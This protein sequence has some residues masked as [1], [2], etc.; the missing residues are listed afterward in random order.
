MTTS[1]L[2]PPSQARRSKRTRRR[3]QDK[4]SISARL[5]LD[6]HEVRGDVGI[7]SEDLFTDLFPHLRDVLSREDGSEDIHHIAIAPWE[8]NPSPTETAWTVVPVLKSSA[9]KPSTVQFSPSSLS[10]QN[11]ATILQQVAPS[12]LSS[13]SRSGIE[14]QILD[15]V[16][17]SLDTVFVSLESELTKR[18]EQGEG[19]FFRD[20]PNH[21]KGKGLVAPETPEGR[22]IASL[23]V[24]LGSLKVLH[25][26][27]LF[28]LPLP[29]HPV[30]HVPPNPGKIMLCE[31]VS[32]GILSEN[33]KIVLMRGRVH[34]KRSHAAPTIP[35]NRGLNGVPEDDEDDTANDQFYSAA[36]DRYKTDAATTEIDSVT[37]TEES[38][39]SGVDHDD[40][41][42]DDSM[43][44]MISLQAPTLPTTASGVSTMQPGTPM[45][46]GRGRKTNGIATPA[47]VFSNFTATTARPDRPRGRLFKAQGLVRPIPVDLLHP[48]PASE[49]DDEARI[50]VD[51]SSLSKIGCF[52]GDWVRVEAAEEPPAN[53]FGAFGLGSFTSLEPTESNWRPVRVY[54]LPEAYSQRPVTRI[55]SAKHGERR[56]SFFESQL[57]KPTSPAAY[58]SPILL[59]NLDSPSYLRL[60]P[61]KRGSYQGKGTLPKFTS[62]SRPPYARDITIQHVRSPVTAE[63]VYQ[64]AVLG[65]LKRYFA[66]KIR[67]VRTGDLLAVPIDTQLG[68]ALQ[69]QPSASNGSEVD[70]VMTLTKNGP[71][72]FDEVA[73]FKV[74]HIQIQKADVEDDQSEDL[75]GG[76]ACIDSSSVAMHGSGFA[77]NRIPAT[78]ASTWP[79]YLGVKKMPTKSPSPSALSLPDQDQRFVSPLRRRLRELLAAATSPRA[80]HLNMP[81]VAILLTSTHRNIGKANVASEACSDIGLHMYAIDAYDILSEAGT[82][83]SDV[84]TEGLLRTRAERAMSCGSDTTALLIRHVEA[85]T[86]DRMVTTMKEILQ[87]TRVLV[88]TTS[89][90]DK[91]PDGVRG[92]FSHELEMGAPDEAERE[93][94]LRTIVEDRGINLDPEVD[95]NSI[96]LK[97]AALV[98]GDLVDV[99][100]R[101][102]IAQRLRLEQISS[103][104]ESTGTV[105]TVRD[106]QIAGG[107]MARCITRGDFDVAVEAARKNFAGAIGAPKIPNVTW[108]DV[109]GLNNVKDAVTETIQL[110]LERPELFAKGMKKRSGILF[111][112]PPGTGK[113]LLAKAIATEYS[114]NFF[115]VKGPELLN[116]YIGESEANVRRVFQRARDARPC[117]VFFDELDSVAPKRGN[118]GD[119]GGVMD[120]IVSQLLA[121]LDGMSGG[122]DTSGGVFVVGATNRPDLLDPALLRP[123]RFDK[124]LYLGVSDTH[125]K[126]LKILEALTRKFT[127]HPSVSLSSVAQQLPFTY[128]G[129][130]FYALCSDA[131]L[132]AVTRQAT[133]VDAKIR[134]INADPAGA[135]RRQGPI[136]TAYFFDH[137][138]TPEDIAVMVTEEDF[139]AANRELVPSVS[140]GEL[141]HY[142]QVRAMFEGSPDKDK[143]QQR[144]SANGLRAVS[145][146]S[147]VSKASSKGK[148]KAVAG[149]IKGKGK[150]VATGSDDEYESEGE[151]TVVNGKGKGK[152]KAVAGFQDGTA[153]DD[154]GLY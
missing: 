27:D 133:S 38:E 52:S 96:A 87:D 69:E 95:L 136:S 147:V 122:D 70:D 89:D 62:A 16:A 12:K 149:G 43:D 17:L 22:L 112:G 86:A 93:G 108:D 129:A 132:K 53:G 58:I 94:I 59:E 85:L 150:A 109:G 146:S 103:K 120:R 13:H 145:A 33:T 9:L 31:P 30:T 140:A 5:I 18:L 91:V 154:E 61:I 6:D 71:P 121:E 152:G 79:Y 84:K 99:V 72:R 153:S 47:S 65:G 24:A 74:G 82:S 77:T 138:A 42:S 51:I 117:V 25:S 55:P 101:A 40:D 125:D 137:H 39:L 115:S 21:L 90:V 83:G 123:G 46:V 139:L 80:I 78:K 14:I 116:M 37:E 143:Q 45:T 64:S 44:D 119:S 4:P 2:A 113:T 134:E 148:G 34:T 8:P 130:D 32:Q 141:A 23:R 128:T 98:A 110:P 60:S 142:E 68:K 105:A 118:Q 124:M 11:F 73:W 106:L 50:F 75:W 144:P 41:L 56:L 135:A 131:M 126:Q 88:A 49:D 57:Q 7:L 63:R 54:G 3:R 107:P 114:L 67:L 48:K 35:P 76:V 151:M 97:T 111:Y 36:E 10:L 26:G 81:P 19:T 104:T 127:L 66:Q 92:L 1:E 20:H 28:P 100:D 15:V 102:L 29:P